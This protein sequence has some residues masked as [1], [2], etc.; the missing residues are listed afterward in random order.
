VIHKP[1][2]RHPGS[3]APVVLPGEATTQYDASMFLRPASEPIQER[4]WA[5]REALEG[6]RDDLSSF[7]ETPPPAP[8]IS[9]MTMNHSPEKPVVSGPYMSLYERLAQSSGPQGFKSNTP[10]SR[11]IVSIKPIN[12]PNAHT[13]RREEVNS[14]TTEHS[15]STPHEAKSSQKSARPSSASRSP[16]G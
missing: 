12:V 15:Q 7:R 16:R 1:P 10:P 9:S 4:L 5:S 3:R 11:P 14:K 13:K 8:S 2:R 6:L